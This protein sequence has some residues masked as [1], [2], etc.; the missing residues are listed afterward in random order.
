MRQRSLPLPLDQER[1]KQCAPPSPP[2]LASTRFPSVKQAA[3]QQTSMLR[4][5]K[6]RQ[7]SDRKAAGPVRFQLV[8]AADD[9]FLLFAAAFLFSM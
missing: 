1:E 5:V 4:N 9:S 2:P 3:V 7:D 8:S 6:R